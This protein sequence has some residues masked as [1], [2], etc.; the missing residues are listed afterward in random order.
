MNDGHY[1]TDFLIGFLV[2]HYENVGDNLATKDNLTYD[3]V[4]QR[5]MDIDTSED[6]NDSTLFVFKLLGN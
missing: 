4:K 1:K 3:E 5:L 2:K 6:L